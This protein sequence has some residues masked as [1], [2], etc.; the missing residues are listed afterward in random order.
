MKRRRVS[1]TE[2]GEWERFYFQICYKGLA[3]TVCLYLIHSRVSILACIMILFFAF[4]GST[5]SVV[6]ENQLETVQN[7]K[8]ELA[9]VKDQLASLETKYSNQKWVID[10]LHCEIGELKDVNSQLKEMV[11]EIQILKDLYLKK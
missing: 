4:I 6:P 9:E 10:S 11:T 3:G 2:D 8:D 1:G 7:L 5:A